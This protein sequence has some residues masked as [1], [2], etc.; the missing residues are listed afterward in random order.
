[1]PYLFIR[2]KSKLTL[3]NINQ[4]HLWDFKGVLTIKCVTTTH[5]LGPQYIKAV[6]S[7]GPRTELL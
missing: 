2:T 3:P 6:L 5:P 4:D 7:T 1:M